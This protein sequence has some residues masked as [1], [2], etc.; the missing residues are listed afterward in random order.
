M[1]KE[2][3]IRTIA[4]AQAYPKFAFCSAIT[5]ADPEYYEHLKAAGIDTASVC[6]HLSGYEHYKFATIHTDLARRAGMTT[7]AFLVT[8]LTNIYE[9][10]I[11]FTRRYNQLN[12]CNGD[13]V[14]I[15]VS[16]QKQV[17]NREE[18]IIDLINLIANYHDRNYIDVAFFKRDIDDAIIDLDK[19][20][21]I[22]NLTITNCN[23]QL[24]GIAEAGSWVYTNKFEG[25]NQ[26][27]A[28]D[29]YGFYTDN[30]GYQLSMIDTDYVVQKG[31]TWYSISRRHGIP[32]L[33]LLVLNR[34]EKTDQLF[35][36]QIVRI[37]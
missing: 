35:A 8:D 23:A 33:D 1:K 2:K 13:K 21:K 37:A 25:E 4:T 26:M 10:M 12:Y 22:V 27:L 32:L 24:S 19:I 31:D 36:G 5:P 15:W 28:Y 18:K 29:F 6:L 7:H 3:V 14:T 17:E 16:T 30:G 9:D 11:H 34:A 20:P